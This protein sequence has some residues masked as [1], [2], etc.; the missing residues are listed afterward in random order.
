MTAYQ[1][2]LAVVY[3]ASLFTVLLDLFIWRPL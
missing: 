3:A 2:I 1:R